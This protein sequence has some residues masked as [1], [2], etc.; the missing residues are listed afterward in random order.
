VERSQIPPWNSQEVY[1]TFTPQSLVLLLTVQCLVL[2]LGKPMEHLQAA[3]RASLTP[4][5]AAE[6][7]VNIGRQLGYFG[8]LTLDA[9]AWVSSFNGDSMNALTESLL[10]RQMQ[11]NSSPWIPKPR[12]KLAGFPT[13]SGLLEFYSALPM[14][15]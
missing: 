15:F 12:R 8:Y 1:G 2:R 14:P 5:P 10:Y 6:Q 9:F 4:G 11:S 3:L 7:V 13:G